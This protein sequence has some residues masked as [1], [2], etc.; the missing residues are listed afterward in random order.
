MLGQRGGGG[1]RIGKEGKTGRLGKWGFAQRWFVWLRVV[2]ATL[3]PS[4][5]TV[6]QSREQLPGPGNAVHAAL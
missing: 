3:L 1:T 6:W 2:D 4:P 5:S